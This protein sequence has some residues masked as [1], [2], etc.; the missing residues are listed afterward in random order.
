MGKHDQI[1]RADFP[2]FVFLYSEQLL[3]IWIINE[4]YKK[5]SDSQANCQNETKTHCTLVQIISLTCTAVR[6][7][8]S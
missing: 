3:Q 5:K 8:V 1:C 7:L 6:Q 2:Y 4:E